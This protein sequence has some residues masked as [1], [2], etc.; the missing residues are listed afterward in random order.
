MSTTTTP[1]LSTAQVCKLIHHL[2]A[3]NWDLDQIIT[4]VNSLG[5]HGTITKWVGPTG[6]VHTHS[7]NAQVHETLRELY[8]AGETPVNRVAIRTTGNVTPAGHNAARRLEYDTDDST[9]EYFKVG[10]RAY[11]GTITGVVQREKKPSK[12]AKATTTAVVVKRNDKYLFRLPNRRHFKVPEND[13]AMLRVAQSA[14]EAQGDSDDNRPAPP[15]PPVPVVPPPPAPEMPTIDFGEWFRV[16]TTTTDDAIMRR[17]VRRPEVSRTIASII[18]A[19]VYDKYTLDITTATPAQLC[20]ALTNFAAA[21]TRCYSRAYIGETIYEILHGYMVYH[22]VIITRHGIN[23]L[24][25]SVL[26][27]C[28]RLKRR[29]EFARASDGFLVDYT[30]RAP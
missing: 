13:H 16:C 20:S 19:K 23:E 3:N 15:Q 8:N 24:R 26:N 29:I 6:V 9:I 22:N 27:R 12:V 18:E 1:R 21:H 11:S 10:D 14:F 4:A 17:L 30:R 7:T 2:H 5:E 28:S 25:T